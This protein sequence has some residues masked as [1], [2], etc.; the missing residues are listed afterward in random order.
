[1]TYGI[2]GVGTN[3]TISFIS[4]KEPTRDNIE[5]LAKILS[6]TKQEKSLGAYYDCVRFIRA[7]AM[8]E[9]KEVLNDDKT[10]NERN[11]Y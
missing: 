5:T 8:V 6:L 10:S 2:D 1:M 11:N 3:I 4:D 9:M 7:E